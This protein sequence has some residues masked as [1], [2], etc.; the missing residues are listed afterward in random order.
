MGTMATKT[1]N[2]QQYFYCAKKAFHTLVIKAPLSDDLISKHLKDDSYKN[3]HNVQE[4]HLYHILV[5]CIF[6]I[7]I[8][9]YLGF[10]AGPL[11]VGVYYVKQEGIYVL[12]HFAL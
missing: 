10:S 7:I 8:V 5:T 6:S 9:T 1:I 3:L 12:K 11:H 4:E 2:N